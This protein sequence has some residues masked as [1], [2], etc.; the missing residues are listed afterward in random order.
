MQVGDSAAQ[1]RRD[2]AR[3]VAFA[4]AAA[5]LLVELD[6][7]HRI[8]YASGAARGLSDCAAE[9]LIGRSV[10]DLFS[11]RDG[12]LRESPVD[13]TVLEPKLRRPLTG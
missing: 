3:F 12:R 9:Q 1:I 10:S 8:A 13:M 4:F 7:E 11:A 5:D 2:R 6:P